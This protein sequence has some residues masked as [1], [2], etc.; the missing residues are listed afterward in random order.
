VD[1]MTFSIGGFKVEQQDF[2]FWRMLAKP[3]ILDLAKSKS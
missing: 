2:E 3:K 1:S